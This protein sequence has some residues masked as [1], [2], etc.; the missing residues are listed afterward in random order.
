MMTLSLT[1]TLFAG[2]HHVHGQANGTVIIEGSSIS[3]EFSI[4]AHDVI[5]FEHHPDSKEEHLRVDEA[6][7]RMSAP[8][9]VSFFADGGWLRSDEQ[10]EITPM[11]NTAHLGDEHESDDHHDDHLMFMV[12]LHYELEEGTQLKALSIDIFERLPDLHALDLVVLAEGQQAKYVLDKNKVK[13]S[14]K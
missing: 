14:I 3:I 5:G 9:L 6:Q 8:N 2:E 12:Q 10:I 11:K 1:T 4:P 13:V 7:K